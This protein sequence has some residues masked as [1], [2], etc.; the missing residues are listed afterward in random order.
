MADEAMAEEKE[1]RLD[2][3]ETCRRRSWN[4]FFC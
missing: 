2:E 1:I 3:R 4:R